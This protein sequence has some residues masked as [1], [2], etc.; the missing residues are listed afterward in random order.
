MVDCVPSDISKGLPGTKGLALRLGGPVGGPSYGVPLAAF[1]A[2][3]A[4]FPRVSPPKL[5]SG[6]LRSLVRA[7]NEA[8]GGES[9]SRDDRA[10]VLSVVR[11]HPGLTFEGALDT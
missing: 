4:R 10:T 5:A 8:F 6:R 3:A 2:H 1:D 9:L 7:Q 11:N